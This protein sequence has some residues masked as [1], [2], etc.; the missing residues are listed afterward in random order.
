MPR[1]RKK[2]TAEPVAEENKVVEA[3]AA[4]AA[5][6]AE[7]EVPEEETAQAAPV[8]VEV[9]EPPK[10]KRGRKPGVKNKPKEV[11][12]EAA[13]TPARKKAVR[14]ISGKMN[15]YVEY[16]ANQYKTEDIIA[17]IQSA[18]VAE[19]HRVGAIKTLNIYIK[20]EAGKAYYVINDKY[21]GDVSI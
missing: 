19:R 5:K 18:W 4:E 16:M 17:S 9:V 8:V 7:V 3:V 14:E 11:K 15:I 12:A 21:A 20:P 10:K 2:S 1:G 13:E 6:E